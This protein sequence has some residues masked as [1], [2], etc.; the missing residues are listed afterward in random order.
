M[1]P[2]QMKVLRW[3][4][5]LK[6]G[7]IF[8]RSWDSSWVCVDWNIQSVAS[9]TVGLQESTSKGQPRS[10]TGRSA[11][12]AEVLNQS[13]TVKIPENPDFSS[14]APN[15]RDQLFYGTPNPNDAQETGRHGEKVAF[16]YFTNLVGEGS[17][18]WVNKERETG[19]PYDIVLGKNEE[20]KEYIEVKATTAARKDWFSITPNER[21]FAVEKGDCFSVVHVVLSDSKKMATITY[22]KNLLKQ[23][24]QGFLHLALLIA[25]KP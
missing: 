5:N 10:G 2:C 13:V 9:L 6:R 22:F 3:K 21:Q 15:E 14:S 20:S 12:S 16:D 8:T 25:K 18:N 11:Y 24:R 23:C 7:L 4:M 1:F 19:L 17:V